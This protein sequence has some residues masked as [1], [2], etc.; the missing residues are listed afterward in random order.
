MMNQTETVKRFLHS[1]I[2]YIGKNDHPYHMQK[3]EVSD[4]LLLI[5]AC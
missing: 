4:T 3:L 5:E 2:H 1:Y